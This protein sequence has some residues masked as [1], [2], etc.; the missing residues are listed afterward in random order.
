MFN[1]EQNDKPYRKNGRRSARQGQRQ[2]GNDSSEEKSTPRDSKY[3]AVID[4]K[5]QCT[6]C[7]ST[8][9]L[10]EECKRKDLECYCCGKIGHMKH[11]C[12]C[13]KCKALRSKSDKRSGRARKVKTKKKGKKGKAASDEGFDKKACSHCGSK[14]HGPDQVCSKLKQKRAASDEQKSAIK[15]LEKSNKKLEQQLK[16]VKKK[17]RSASQPPSRSRKDDSDS[18][19]ESEW[20]DLDISHSDSDSVEY[21][22]IHQGRFARS[23]ATWCGVERRILDMQDL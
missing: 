2:R 3:P 16:K 23:E 9:H 18:A 21:D 13:D 11:V 12:P 15:A 6:C 17:A 19:D 8:A 5:K 1:P 10:F 20:S 4:A 22:S 14:D 7:G